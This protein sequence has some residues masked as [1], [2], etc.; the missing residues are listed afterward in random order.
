VSDDTAVEETP[1]A[2]PVD[3][4]REALLAEVTEALG[5]AILE[6][7]IRVNE[8]LWIR[9]KAVAWQD[10]FRALK[11]LGFTYFGFISAIDWSDAPEGRYE[12]TEFDTE[13]VAD[14]AGEAATEA[15]AETTGYAGG[16]TK[17]QMIASLSS[18]TRHI[19]I[20]IKADVT[21]P[22]S[23]DTVRDIFAGADWHERELFEMFGIDV[24]GHPGLYPLYLP[25]EFEGHPLRKDFPLLARQVKPWPGVVDIEEIPAHLE[26]QLE[27]EVMAA[28]EAAGGGQ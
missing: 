10:T 28:F 3:D 11:N 26:E 22:G 17:F 6:S 4:V 9:V 13:P 14:E 27:A 23:I 15:P 21:D 5:D 18:P 12:D 7:H 8:N 1:E 20:L 16:D 19:P 25:T 2:A 24:I